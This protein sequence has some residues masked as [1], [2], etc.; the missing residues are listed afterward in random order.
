M[1]SSAGQTDSVNKIKKAADS[2][3]NTGELVFVFLIARLNTPE[4]KHH[5]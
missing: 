5:K 4:N 1:L 3:I 2:V